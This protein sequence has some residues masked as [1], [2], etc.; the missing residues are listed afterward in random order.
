MKLVLD[1]RE[2]HLKAELLK[3]NADFTT[4]QL[5]IGDI[6]FKTDDDEVV[7]ILE[8]KTSTD[9]Y[10]SI[11][12]GRFR[13]QRERL[14]AAGVRIC[15]IIEGYKMDA[16][17]GGV[18]TNDLKVAGGALENLV[19]YHN[20]HILP[21]MSVQHTASTLMNIKKKLEEKSIVS[22]SE[23]NTPAPVVAVFTQ[24]KEKVLDHIYEHQLLLIPG[25]SPLVAK[26]IADKYPSIRSLFSA[27]DTL[28]SEK[29]KW[30][31]LANLFVGKKRL[32]KILSKRIYDVYNDSGVDLTRKDI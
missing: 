29:E 26:T 9:L 11:I 5:A 1:T 12:S 20:I 31:L 30:E 15:Y 32:G 24:K 23:K 19:L 14:K 8:R 25:V 28:E 17:F 4:E 13:E 6:V 27:W 16:K 7:L 21:T 2:T 18:F 22:T 10:S 3:G